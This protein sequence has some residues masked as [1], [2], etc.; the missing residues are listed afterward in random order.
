VRS[1]EAEKPTGFVSRDPPV[2]LDP[3]G[4]ELLLDPGIRDVSAVCSRAMPGFKATRLGRERS[5]HV[6]AMKKKLKISTFQIG[7]PPRPGQGLRVGVTRRP[8]R[9]VPKSHWV[10]GGYFDVWLP[11]LA[12]S[13]SR[14]RRLKRKDYDDPAVRK[15]F[16]NSYERELLA[17][18]DSRQT[19]EFV[20]QVAMR[21]PISIG[22]F[23][24][25]ES[26]CHRSRL[27]KILRRHAPP[28]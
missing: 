1:P 7:T 16:F 5:S 28:E 19:V 10:A 26:R 15:A 11:A 3:D 6:E 2:I 24:E 13:A 22:C 21:T 27:L 9:G 4:Y 14:L 25:D 17:T 12:P 20:A 8:P 23:C 18:A